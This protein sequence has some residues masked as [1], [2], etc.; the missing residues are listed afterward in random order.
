MLV[1]PPILSFNLAFNRTI[2]VPTD[3]LI[4]LPYFPAGS[5]N[6]RQHLIQPLGE[7]SVYCIQL[8]KSMAWLDLIFLSSCSLPA[9]V[10]VFSLSDVFFSKIHLRLFLGFCSDHNL[11][12]VFGLNYLFIINVFCFCQ[13]PSVT[14]FFYRNTC[15]IAIQKFH[16]VPFLIPKMFPLTVLLSPIGAPFVTQNNFEYDMSCEVPQNKKG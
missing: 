8:L 4:I 1:D 16:S 9:W 12:N 2:T 6:R 10:C 14:I 5:R 13:Y 11:S 3:S 15:T 7:K